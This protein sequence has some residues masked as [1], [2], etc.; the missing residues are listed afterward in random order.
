MASITSSN[1]EQSGLFEKTFVKSSNESGES[2]ILTPSQRLLAHFSFLLF[3][4]VNLFSWNA[5]VVQTMVNVFFYSISK[6]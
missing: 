1:S 3:G 2:E 6:T 5:I 4:I